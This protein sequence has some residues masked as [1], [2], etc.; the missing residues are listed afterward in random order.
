M[1]PK[2]PVYKLDS[3]NEA[4]TY[5]ESRTFSLMT[6]KAKPISYTLNSKRSQQ[7]SRQVMHKSDFDLLEELTKTSLRFI[8][9]YEAT[10][11]QVSDYIENP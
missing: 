11:Q 8:P 3:P 1:A 5:P 6:V 9:V 2:N 10:M 4:Y 7:K